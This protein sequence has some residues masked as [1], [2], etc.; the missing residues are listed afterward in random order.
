[1][2]S[3]S[4]P[5]DPEFDALL[6]RTEALRQRYARAT[7]AEQPSAAA[8]ACIHA[9]AW[10]AAGVT[11][12]PTSRSWGRRLRVPVS[13]AAVLVLTMSAMLS[14]LRDT[15]ER[16]LPDPSPPMAKAPATPMPTVVA[17]A[18]RAMSPEASRSEPRSASREKETKP[19]APFTGQVATRPAEAE[20]AA[21][22]S[23]TLSADALGHAGGESRSSVATAPTDDARTAMAGGDRSGPAASPIDNLKSIERRQPSDSASSQRAR[24]EVAAAAAGPQVTPRTDEAAAPSPAVATRRDAI[25][26]DMREQTVESDLNPAAPAT[27]AKVTRVEPA[28]WLERIR[29]QWITGAH[30]AASRQLAAFLQAHPAYAIP[31]DFPVPLPPVVPDR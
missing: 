10:Q 29:R 18:T 11:S 24:S 15:G 1:M 13:I 23:P 4:L 7:A 22:V 31:K 20:V 30:E 5:P 26:R 6:A 17:D 2:N 19:A 16:S 21:Q 9:A 27:L 3:P 8:D 12:P 14:M 28:A 25:A